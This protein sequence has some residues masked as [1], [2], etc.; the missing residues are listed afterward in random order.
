MNVTG[1]YE[2]KLDTQNGTTKAGKSWS[3]ETI[4]VTTTEEYD[5]VYPIEFFG[6]KAI[7]NLNN[8][9]VGDMVEVEFNIKANEYNGRHYVSLG[10]WKIAKVE[11]DTSTPPPVATPAEI[12]NE[13]N[14]LPF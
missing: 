4:I 14:P 3:K 12:V 8:A 2:R 1:R 5:N 10:G 6:D 11:S 7:A 9:T 13:E